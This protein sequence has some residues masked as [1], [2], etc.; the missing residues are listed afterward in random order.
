MISNNF[1]KKKQLWLS[2]YTIYLSNFK[3]F[4][5]IDKNLKYLNIKNKNL[6]YLNIKNKNLVN[7]NSYI[8]L[9][10]DSTFNNFF[11]NNNFFKKYSQSRS[12]NKSKKTSLIVFFKNNVSSYNLDLAKKK[13][14][15]KFNYYNKLNHTYI[16]QILY[17]NYNLRLISLS[18]TYFKIDS[19]LWLAIK[20]ILSSSSYFSQLK[21]QK[22][23][24]ISIF[25]RNLV[26]SIVSTNTNKQLLSYKNISNISSFSQKINIESG[27]ILN[28]VDF[29][30][31]K[32]FKESRTSTDLIT[33]F[34]NDFIL[35][36]TS[37]KVKIIVPSG[38]TA[39]LPSTVINII[40]MSGNRF[41]G[42]SNS[43][44]IKR[45]N[46]KE[47]YSKKKLSLIFFRSSLPAFK[48]KLLLT[49]NVNNYGL[50]N[51]NI[52][53]YKKNPYWKN[54]NIFKGKLS[55]KNKYR[56]KNLYLKP[57]KKKNKKEEFLIKTKLEPLIIKP[58][59][60]IK[61][62]FMYKMYFKYKFKKFYK[63]SLLIKRFF[64]NRKIRNKN[65]FFSIKNNSPFNWKNSFSKVQTKLKLYKFFCNYTPWFTKEFFSKNTITANKYKNWSNIFLNT[66]IKRKK[67][68]IRN[69]KK[70]KYKTPSKNKINFKSL[71][72][73]QKNKKL[74]H[75]KNTPKLINSKFNLA[76]Y[77]FKSSKNK[78]QKTIFQ[79]LLLK[80]KL[81]FFLE[82]K[83]LSNLNSK[84]KYSNKFYRLSK[85]SK[86]RLSQSALNLNFPI[87]ISTQS[88]KTKKYFNHSTKPSTIDQFKILNEG[89]KNSKIRSLDTNSINKKF[90]WYQIFNSEYFTVL[91]L[92]SPYLIKLFDDDNLNSKKNYFSIIKKIISKNKSN[93][94][95]SNILPSKCFKYTLTRKIYNRTVLNTTQEPFTPWYYHTL[96]RFLEHQSG[97][98]SLFQFY[99]FVN[100][101]VEPEYIAR[102]KK[103]IP[104]L[105]YY[106]R[107]LGHK[108]F[109][110]EA[111]HIMH[112]SFTLKD[113][114]LICSWLKAIILRISF[115]KTRS[116]FRF[117]KY[118]INVYF[119]LTFK[120]LG[121]KGLKIR[122]KGKISAAGN[123][124]K[125]T[126]LYRAGKTSHSQVS[127]RV[128]NEFMTISTFTGVMGFQVWLF[129]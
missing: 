10:F 118:L 104:R 120:D 18:S 101:D 75:K 100:N 60:K 51:F 99:P 107:R 109:L 62:S 46:Q 17:T 47:P 77:S 19:K 44:F 33:N 73:Y 72:K 21:T 41:S 81:K 67:F 129:Y 103:W 64:D 71:T 20:Y 98:K 115:W 89:F 86:K 56:L 14:L 52:T 53:K 2:A 108:F 94:F 22:L 113:P 34:L 27:K 125:R 48:Q 43:Q 117:L 58:S 40:S 54:I 119:K 124:R 57:N 38:V 106:E 80:E 59:V 78:T 93:L 13:H 97:K 69:I 32:N 116:I 76:K 6:K 30:K 85:F 110:E 1:F 15:S 105:A 114:K 36:K 7:T 90:N 68:I 45:L 79:K 112:L 121:L 63:N 11:K 25:N 66:K 88:Y 111:L 29:Y 24:N 35:E 42:K 39:R 3:K 61:S 37:K 91:F 26:N 4:K 23:T 31:D 92:N 82:Q 96:I 12:I 123:S 9:K 126:I 74:P 49:S 128:V 122:L 55:L 83:N 8:N 84:I 16:W 127:L 28:N 95:L 5:N 87:S 102:Y 65:F 50:G 70:Y